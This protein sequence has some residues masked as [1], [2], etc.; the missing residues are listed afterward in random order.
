MA[1]GFSV[2]WSRID[3]HLPG[4]MR[5]GFTDNEIAQRFSVPWSTLYYHITKLGLGHLRQRRLGGGKSRDARTGLPPAGR[6]TPKVS[7]KGAPAPVRT[8]SSG[9]TYVPD[10]RLTLPRGWGRSFGRDR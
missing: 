9:T 4:L 5:L 8:V 7:A 3:P 10:G 6:R 1:R 2:D